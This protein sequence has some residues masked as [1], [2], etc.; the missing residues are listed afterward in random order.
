M[1]TLGRERKMRISI[2][3]SAAD[4]WNPY[5]F[6]MSFFWAQTTKELINV[7][8]SKKYNIKA[9]AKINNCSSQKITG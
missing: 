9:N 2:S 7:V 4:S 6:V 3:I 5:F 1:L 8:L